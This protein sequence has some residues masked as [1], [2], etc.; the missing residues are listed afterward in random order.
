[1]KVSNSTKRFVITLAV[2]LVLVVSYQAL[3]DWAMDK[4]AEALKKCLPDEDTTKETNKEE[5]K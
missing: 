1:M 3:L 4:T 2:G 5:K